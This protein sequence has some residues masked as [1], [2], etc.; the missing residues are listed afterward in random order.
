MSRMLLVSCLM[1]LTASAALAQ[2]PESQSIA[3]LSYETPHYQLRVFAAGHFA[4]KIG[5][6][7]M[8]GCICLNINGTPQY[9]QE[10]LSY[11]ASTVETTPDGRKMTV[12]G[13]LTP[14]FAFTQTLV[15][16]PQAVELTYV[17]EALKAAQV[18]DISIT[19]GPQLDQAKGL[20]VQVDAAS[21]P[22]EFTF[23]PAAPGLVGDVRS[24]TWRNLSQRDARTTF[25]QAWKSSVAVSE[26]SA[27]YTAVLAR[28][29]ELKQGDKL[30]GIMRF[31]AVPIGE[32]VSLRQSFQDRLGFTR[33]G[34]SGLA[35]LLNN[36]RTDQGLLIQQLSI[37]EDDVHQVQVG[38]GKAV[39][40]GGVY[41]PAGQ[42]GAFDIT[43]RGKVVS[44]WEERIEARALSP[45]VEEIHWSATRK[46]AANQ[47]RLRVLMYVAQW[48]EQERNPYFI[49]L[50]DG[51]RQTDSQGDALWFGMPP[52][53]TEAGLGPYRKLGQFPAGTEIVVPMLRRGELMTV[54]THQPLEIDGFRFEIY[55]RGLWFEAL[56]KTLPQLAFDIKVEKLPLKQAGPLT[57]CEDPWSSAAAVRVGGMPLLEAEAVGADGRTAS[58]RWEWTSD[59]GGASGHLRAAGV[60]TVRL[61]L[62][63]F[64]QGKPPSLTAEYARQVTAVSLA[65]LESARSG[66]AV[67]VCC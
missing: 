23:P 22:R 6:S 53:T 26:K 37:N 4:V 9:K 17:V 28:D 63:E 27:T 36:V 61:K 10:A 31:E 46:S 2:A 66:Q 58:A 7:W 25:V 11:M 21:G 32:A 52:Q 15:M 14:D 20:Q 45:T 48:L 19:A 5:G 55:F 18:K 42:P 60:P 47:Q 29:R 38:R 54:R 62:P 35:G 39:A 51:T 65:A 3:G 1:L 12:T 13:R 8:P 24:I 16:S 30:T 67:Q 64:L 40:W 41:V 59:R 50:P 57:V 49:R 33:L 34:V 44:D 56:D 43:S